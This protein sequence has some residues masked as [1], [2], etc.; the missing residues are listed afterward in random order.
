MGPT[1]EMIAV[2]QSRRGEEL[3][4]V[5]WYW[6]R[7]FIEDNFT[8]EC[9]NNDAP[10][11]HIMVKATQIGTNEVDIRVEKD[12]TRVPMG[13]KEFCSTIANSLSESKREQH[14]IC[15]ER[16]V[17]RMRKQC[18]IF[19]FLE[20]TTWHRDSGQTAAK[21]PSQGMPFSAK[22]AVHACA[23][24]APRLPSICPDATGV[25]LP[26]IAT[27]PA[28]RRTGRDTR[29]GAAKRES[30]SERRWSKRET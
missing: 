19:L 3:A 14:P 1:I 13:F 26:S 15:S 5:L 16:D 20:R 9:L 27:K 8:I 17:P 24:G 10:L 12:G 18:S 22:S 30:K 2:K 11:R 6:V 29:N 25:A 21:H 7:R 28:K 4:K 23:T